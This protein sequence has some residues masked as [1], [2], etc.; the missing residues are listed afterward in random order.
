MTKATA[1]VMVD[2]MVLNTLVLN[3]ST[4]NSIFGRH[5]G[6]LVDASREDNSNV[7][8]AFAYHTRITNS[9]PLGPERLCHGTKSIS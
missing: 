2:G 6:L 7:K 4:A 5:Y 9:G 3:I 1:I 8:L